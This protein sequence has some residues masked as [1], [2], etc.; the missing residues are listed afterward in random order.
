MQEAATLLASYSDFT[1]F[2]KTGHNASSMICQ[3]TESLWQFDHE[4]QTARYRVSA[5]RFLRGMVRLLVG[6]QIQVG[7]K[8]MSL[9]ELQ[10]AL[11]NQSYLK[12]SVSV[13]PEGL[14]LTEV[15][16]PWN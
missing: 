11:D 15:K 5:N 1:P 13:P 6:A 8:K 12:K 14:S 7:I 4:N 2:C 3:L 16:Y 10:Y 9:G